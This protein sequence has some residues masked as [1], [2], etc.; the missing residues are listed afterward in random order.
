MRLRNIKGAEEILK[1][2]PNIIVNPEDN[3]GNW[4]SIFNNNNPIHLEIGMGKGDFI[5]ALAAE[6]PNINFIGIEKQASVLIRAVQKAENL[7]PNL[8]LIN[9]DANDL[10]NIFNHEIDAIYLNHSD[11]WPKAK[12]AKRRLTSPVFL[13]LYKQIAN[14]GFTLYMRTDNEQLFDYSLETFAENGYMIKNINRNLP[15]TNGV[16]TEYE[17]KFRKLGHLIYYLEATYSK[18]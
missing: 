10:N 2:N 6:Y 8:R 4:A 12:H 5:L 17:K 18:K 15:V 3:K 1:S 14:D 13:E 9:A 7:I 11:P 16:M